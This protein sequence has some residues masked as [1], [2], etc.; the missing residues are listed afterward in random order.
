M[1]HTTQRTIRVFRYIEELDA[2]LPTECYHRIAA[3]LG[4]AEWTPVVWIGRLFFLDNDYGEHWHD[5]WEA[6]E[7]RRERAEA[8]GI[9][10]YDLLIL[11]P[12]RMQNGVDGPCHSVEQRKRFWTDVM[13]SLALGEETLFEEARAANAAQLASER[14]YNDG[15]ARRGRPDLTMPHFALDD[16]EGRIARVRA[17]LRDE[18]AEDEPAEDERGRSR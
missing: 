6:R 5:N 17:W 3:E 8:I 13:R 1:S 7:E 16:L 18:P 10:P 11:D 14:S 12:E 15:M 2:F 4:L 9:D